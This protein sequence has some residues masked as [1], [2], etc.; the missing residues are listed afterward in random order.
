MVEYHKYVFDQSERKFLGRFEDMYK[1]E[2]ISAFDSWHQDDLRLLDVNI[3]RAILNQYAFMN[4][5]HVGC[6]KGALTQFLKKQNNEVLALDVSSSAIERAKARYPDIKFRQVDVRQEG[7]FRSV[8]GVGYDLLT[9][10]ELLSYVEHWQRLLE[11]FAQLAR[12][13]LIKLF[14]PDDPIGYVKTMDALTDEFSKHFDIV[15]NIQMINHKH[16]IL[17]GRSILARP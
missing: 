14:L 4:V 10:L 2:K 11:D 1:A 17:F 13:T 8:A 7:W 16:I 5:L 6:G 15:E 9:C 3:C 12:F